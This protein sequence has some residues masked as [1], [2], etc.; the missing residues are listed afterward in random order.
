MLAAGPTAAALYSSTSTYKSCASVLLGAG[1]QLSRSAPMQC[2]AERPSAPAEMTSQR[3]AR[4][5]AVRR[6][7]CKGVCSA[8]DCGLVAE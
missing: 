3:R 7:S 4:K 6:C 8:D 1:Q 5:A 2:A